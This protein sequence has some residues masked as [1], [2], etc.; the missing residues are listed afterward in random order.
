MS[1]QYIT[2][3]QAVEIHKKTVDKSGGGVIGHLELGKLEGVLENIK[4]DIYYPTFADKLT[5]LFF[6]ACKFHSFIDGNKRIAITLSAQFLLLNG[7]LYCTG[8]FIREME[9]ISYHVA[10]GSI[11]KKLLNEIMKAFLEEKM[12]SEV[13]KLKLLNAIAKDV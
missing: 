7:Y 3:E 5:H 6:C 12:D 10:D 8:Q 11:D 4:N 1:I 13:L 9:N 2:I